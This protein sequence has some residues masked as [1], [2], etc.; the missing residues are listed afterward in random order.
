MLVW[1]GTGGGMLYVQRYNGAVSGVNAANVFTPFAEAANWMTFTAK[2]ATEGFYFSSASMPSKG[3]EIV[4][5]TDT[6]L[7]P[8][9]TTPT[10]CGNLFYDKT[11]STLL[12]STGTTLYRSDLPPDGGSNFVNIANFIGPGVEPSASVADITVD[13]EGTVYVAV[14]FGSNASSGGA[15]Q[16][17]NPNYSPNKA[18]FFDS[19]VGVRAIAYDATSNDLIVLTGSTLE[20][21]SLARH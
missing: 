1:G 4:D 2:D 17:Y 21:V 15:V 8:F 19:S 7:L 3:T 11:S 10:S 14:T 6:M 20:R 13:A 18:R 16:A 5:P 12:C 9:S